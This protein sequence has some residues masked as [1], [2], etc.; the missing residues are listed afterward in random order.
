MSLDIIQITLANRT[1]K[2]APFH[3]SALGSTL[4]IDYVFPYQ[5]SCLLFNAIGKL[6]T[7]RR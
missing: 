5:L 3:C 4:L 7:S 2:D 1:F 6:S